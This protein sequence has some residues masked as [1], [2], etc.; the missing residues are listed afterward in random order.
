MYI[1]LVLSVLVIL[2]C[3]MMMTS[4]SRL[5]HIPGHPGHPVF[6]HLLMVKPTTIH[7]QFE[8]WSKRF[9]PI[10]RLQLFHFTELVVSDFDTIYEVIGEY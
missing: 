9:G 5:D 6:G 10:N 1:A 7:K 4:K 2:T 8:A 3:Y